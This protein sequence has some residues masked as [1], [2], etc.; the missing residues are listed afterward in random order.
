MAYKQHNLISQNQELISQVISD[1]NKLTAEISHHNF[2]AWK[3][4]MT[5]FEGKGMGE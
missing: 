3:E 5:I 2:Q 4:S 1:L